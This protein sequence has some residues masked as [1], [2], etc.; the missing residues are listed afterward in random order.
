[1]VDSSHAAASDEEE[2][3]GMSQIWIVSPKSNLPDWSV[4][5]WAC[6]HV[7][8]CIP[9]M[10][11]PLLLPQRVFTN[12]RLLYDTFTSSPFSHSRAPLQAAT[13]TILETAI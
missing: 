11:S 12:D 6:Q 4:N 13:P 5:S 9:S 7:A 8:P 10:I 1:M 3:E 2:A